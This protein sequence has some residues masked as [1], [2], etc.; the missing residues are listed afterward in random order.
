MTFKESEVLRK[1]EKHAGA[2]SL[3]AM[4]IEAIERVAAAKLAEADR[5]ARVIHTIV[6]VC[7]LVFIAAVVS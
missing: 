3:E 6:L 1:R 7:V 5:H 2:D 4:R